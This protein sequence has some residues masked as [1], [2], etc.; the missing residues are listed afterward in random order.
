[1]NPYPRTLIVDDDDVIALGLQGYLN[2]RGGEAHA[3]HDYQT[4]RALAGC[5]HYEVALVD[6]V[7]TGRGQESGAEF[8]RWLREASPET[9]VVVLT[10]FRTPWLE[11]FA[12]SLGITHFL[13]KPKSFDEILAALSSLHADASP[14]EGAH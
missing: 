13:D 5:A 14:A 7:L 9:I 6:V 10:A 4:A 8:L 11:D 3:A 2:L 12:R 1:M